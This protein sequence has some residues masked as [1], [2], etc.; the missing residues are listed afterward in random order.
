[1]KMTRVASALQ[2]VQFRHFHSARKRI[3]Q[4]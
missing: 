2:N 3:A 4:M 1:V